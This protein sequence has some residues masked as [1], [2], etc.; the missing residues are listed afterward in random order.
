MFTKMKFWLIAAVTCVLF[1]YHTHGTISKPFRRHIA[2]NFGEEIAERLA[3]E[4]VGWRGSFGGSDEEGVPKLIKVPIVFVHGQ[5][6]RARDL[7]Y[8]LKPFHAHGYSFAEVYGTTYGKNVTGTNYMHDRAYCDYIKQVRLMIEAVLNYTTYPK[9]D[10]VGFSMGVP[11]SKKAILGGRCVDTG[12]DLGAPL[13][14]RIRTWLGVA[15]AHRGMIECREDPNYE[16][17]NPI[18]GLNPDGES[19]YLADINT[20][21]RYES[22]TKILGIESIDDDIVGPINET[23]RGIKKTER[24]DKL[25]LLQ[26]IGHR[27]AVWFLG[28]LVYELL[29]DQPLDDLTSIEDEALEL[30]RNLTDKDIGIDYQL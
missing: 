25:V 29:T 16:L 26:R 7:D 21:V 30:S 9:V 20:P 15:G 1:V 5:T 17:C 3:R 12:E 14:A 8:V 13:T 22:K 10:V 27:A 11:F 28:D 4:D 18:N 24:Y 2:E 23:H 19:K 6:R